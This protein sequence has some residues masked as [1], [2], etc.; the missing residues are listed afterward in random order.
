VKLLIA[1]F[2]NVLHED[3]GFGVFLAQRVQEHPNLPAGADVLEAGIGGISL[4]QDLMKGYDALI[5]LDALEGDTPGAVKT[6]TAE[7]PDA[8]DLPRDFLADVHYA[9]P[10]RA[11][12]L[13]KAIE[14]LPETVYI[15][16]SVA[17]SAELG[18]GLSPEVEASLDTALRVVLALA[19]RLAANPEPALKGG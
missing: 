14:V 1:G 5:V 10:G 3:D 8:K 18:E 6:L 16:G 4:V 13:A 19:E 7:V 2:G 9:E 17:K 12:V 11:L 15:V